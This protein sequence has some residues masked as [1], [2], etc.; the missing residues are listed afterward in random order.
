MA[1]LSPEIVGEV[2]AACKAGAS[3]AAG[4][5]SRAL[6]TS[7]QVTPGKPGSLDRDNLPEGFDGPGLAVV[8]KV[9]PSAALVL[10]PESSGLVPGWVANPDPTG[11]SKLETLAQELGMILL[12]EDLMPEGFQ[13][14]RVK[15]LAGA[16]ARGDVAT[17][18]A[19]VP[20][21]LSASKS[22][23]G[24]AMLI[25]PTAKPDAVLGAAATDKGATEAEAPKKPKPAQPSTAAQAARG[26]GRA[27]RPRAVSSRELPHYAKSLLRVRI[28]VVV[29]LARKRQPLGSVLELGPGSI[30]H[31]EK[32]CEEMLDLEAGNNPIASG[33]AVKIGDKFGLRVTSVR[34]PEERFHTL[35]RAK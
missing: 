17:G 18:A 16:L 14:G 2:V 12:P 10:L 33:E 7:I 25:W 21:E 1:T 32:S 15:T 13:A 6:D 26:P 8:L 11:K 34:L 5:F 35:R 19:A 27:K 20:L 30:I 3:E 4:A 23:R 24:T 29:T 28:P 31:F 22:A 9:G